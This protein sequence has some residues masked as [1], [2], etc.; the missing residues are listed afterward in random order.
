MPR[1]MPRIARQCTRGVETTEGNSGS[2]G[3]SAIL[4]SDLKRA[5][6]DAAANN[7]NTGTVFIPTR[8]HRMGFCAQLVG[9]GR[10]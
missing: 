3:K 2:T 6:I 5:D 8:G 4:F 9:E 10:V 1:P 7:N